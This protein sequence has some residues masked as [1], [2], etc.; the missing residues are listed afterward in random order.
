LPSIWP[1]EKP[2]RS[3][4]IFAFMI[5]AALAALARLLPDGAESWAP[6]TAS[7]LTLP[8]RLIA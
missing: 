5:V 4:R 1:G 3:S 2:A 8:D 7:S 6:L